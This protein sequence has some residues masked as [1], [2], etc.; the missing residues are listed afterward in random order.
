M[1]RQ[2]SKYAEYIIIVNQR[3]KF[4]EK[5]NLKKNVNKRFCNN[6][7]YKLKLSPQLQLDLALG[8]LNLNPPP[9]NSCE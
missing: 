1:Q 5:I 3:Q 6:Y 2:A 8:L 9:I 7:F 4:V